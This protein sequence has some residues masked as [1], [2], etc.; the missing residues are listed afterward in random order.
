MLNNYEKLYDA[1][2][3]LHKATDR[4]SRILQK[5]NAEANDLPLEQR[6]IEAENILHFI[7]VGEKTTN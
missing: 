2:E 1:T 7:A 6:I 3:Q 4:F 5:F